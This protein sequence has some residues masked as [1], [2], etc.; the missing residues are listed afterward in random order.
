MGKF[1]ELLKLG[2]IKGP[3]QTSFDLSKWKAEFTNS[4]N[5]DDVDKSIYDA[6]L[7]FDEEF[8]GIR[9]TTKEA[10]AFLPVKEPKRMFIGIAT[11]EWIAV[12]GKINER[13]KSQ[14]KSDAVF[15]QELLYAPLKS[16]FGTQISPQG[17][18][19][20][21]VDSIRFPL[22]SVFP[23]PDLSTKIDPQHAVEA[24]RVLF[25]MGQLYNLLEQ[26]WLEL[27]WGDYRYKE[28]CGRIVITISSNSLHQVEAISDFR[29]QSRLNE[30]I[31]L[32]KDVWEY[33]LPKAFKDRELRK[34]KL[35]TIL[36]KPSGKIR[37]KVSE[38]SRYE[39][40]PDSAPISHI[41]LTHEYIDE[42]IKQI[43]PQ[44]C[45]LR[46][47]QVIL[48]YDL[49]SQIPKQMLNILPP[50]SGIDSVERATSYAP[51][52]EKNELL[53]AFRSALDISN[54]QS[55]YLIQYMTHNGSVREQ[56]WFKPIIEM[57]DEK[58][59]M[60][61]PALDGV[62]YFRLVDRLLKDIPNAE[63]QMGKLFENHVRRSLIGAASKFRFAPDLKVY[64][65]SLKFNISETE[66]EE[67]DLVFAVGNK[68]YI[69]E[70]KASLYPVDPLEKYHYLEKLKADGVG[71]AL[72]KVDFVKKH[73]RDFLAKVEFPIDAKKLEVF[74]LVITNNNLYCGYPISG[75]PV[76]DILILAR[77]FDTGTFERLVIRD[78]KGN[79]TPTEIEYFY[80]TRSEATD[81]F[82]GYL[83]HPPQ[84]KCFENY[85]HLDERPFPTA[86]GRKTAFFCALEVRPDYEAAKL[87]IS[88]KKP[89]IS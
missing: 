6:G 21:L 43:F 11:R 86:K 9:K 88:S 60:L 8:Q 84:V 78:E 35:F 16:I 15:I 67:I 17:I 33:Q 5:P 18:I 57:P 68:I 51:M 89:K 61:L 36:K 83:M 46:L 2:K 1:I 3:Q 58:I 50:D 59:S 66:F 87:S 23:I 69:G 54:D 31:Q 25:L 14:T 49:L 48:A 47:E 28:V 29:R 73:L 26:L 38:A 10:T 79:M 20:S 85:L 71:Q 64:A 19:D 45:N 34:R 75:V 30:T 82:W 72:R 62:H 37:I 32:A 44:F 40:N 27:V 42:F 81:N 12:R 52:F 41:F 74:P 63:T 4:T 22:T 56:L 53:N 70:S 65:K 55:K 80:K 76:C 13:I 24:S 77:Y 7:W 39:D